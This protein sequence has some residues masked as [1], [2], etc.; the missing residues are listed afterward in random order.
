[1]AQSKHVV[2]TSRL[3]LIPFSLDLMK[4]TQ[5]LDSNRRAVL[6]LKYAFNSPRNVY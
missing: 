2:E 4:A 6:Y 5:T 3:H 1:M